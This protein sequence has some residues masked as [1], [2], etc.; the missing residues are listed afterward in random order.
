MLPNNVP[1]LRL[2]AAD[3]LSFRPVAS[4]L[5]LAACCASCITFPPPE[6]TMDEAPVPTSFTLYDNVAPAPERWWEQFHSPELDRL[7]EA[8]LAGNL[9][10]QQ[11]FA[12]LDQAE[13]VARQTGAGRWPT[14][15]VTGDISAT[16]R[17]IDT[18]APTPKIETATEKVNAVNT[19][20]RN[21]APDEA[22]DV[23]A[24]ASGALQSAQSSLRALETLGKSPPSSETTAIT[25]AYRLGF[26]TSYEADLW[27]RVRAQHRAA[28]LDYEA[29]IE[30]AYGA[31][32]SLAGQV[33]TQWL[34]VVALEQELDLVRTQ[35][36]LNQ[37]TLSLIEFR[38]RKGRATALD[39]FQQRQIVAQTESLLP[40]LE[41]D[42]QTGRQELAVLL[43]RPPL[44]ELDISVGSLPE[45][46]PLPEPGLPVEL[47]ARRP[48]VRARGLQLQAADWR[49][50]AA[51][52]DRLP[53]LRLTGS[54]SYGAESR[55][56][57]FDN[58]MAVL[59]GSL[60]GPV[61]DAGRRK[62]EVLRTK[63]V[64]NERLAAYR[65]SVLTAVNEV[66][67]SLLQE[68]KQTEYI[69]ALQR[70]IEGARAAHSQAFERYRKGLNDYL[71]VLSALTQLQVL[72]RRMVQANLTRLMLRV[73][74]CMALGGSW[75]DDEPT[76]LMEN[77][78]Q[79]AMDNGRGHRRAGD[80]PPEG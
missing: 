71:P 44:S 6:R 57:I 50:S 23:L 62:A 52:A 17:H 1:L 35:L 11:I 30:D 37:T 21:L 60:T 3:A 67:S 7:V 25:H 63:A 24:A 66:E 26:A 2:R 15:N 68:V 65:Q 42:L 49:V 8:A 59:A 33:V 20:L 72:E 56:L 14:L 27:G 22:N 70:E 41:S 31:I 76:T 53:A 29:S 38:F 32:L 28:L 75:M 64:V 10:L 48:D 61:F 12:R 78:R 51:R 45:L 58:W 5:F 36:E 69:D 47:L 16:R 40:R 79:D 18:G 34:G 43:G 74:A 80:K 9:T 54:A 19:L 55:D 4:L 46:G 39:V 73:K 77:A 13:M